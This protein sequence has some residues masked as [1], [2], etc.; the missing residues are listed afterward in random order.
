MIFL[1]QASVQEI[2][3]ELV[4]RALEPLDDRPSGVADWLEE[5]PERW[6]AV[7]IDRICLRPKLDHPPLG[8]LVKLRDLP[9]DEWNCDLLWLLTKDKSLVEEFADRELDWGGEVKIYDPEKLMSSS[10]SIRLGIIGCCRFGGID[11]S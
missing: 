1:E 4:R 5:N 2:Q 9:S 3:L 7:L 10:G 8:Y 6:E 11:A